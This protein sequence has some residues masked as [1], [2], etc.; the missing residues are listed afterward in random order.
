MTMTRLGSAA[1][2]LLASIGVACGGDSSGPS[3]P[4][5]SVNGVWSG[6][7]SGITITDTLSQNSGRHI[8]GH[9]SIASINGALA[10]TVSGDYVSDSTISLT[11]SSAGYQDLNFSGKFI[12]LDSVSGQL[13]G[14]GFNG[15]L[16]TLNKN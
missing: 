2:V 13:N 7:N 4:G 1:L 11:M 14:S 5:H 12:D 8:T 6:S 16:L 15:F 3:H 10:L 9:G